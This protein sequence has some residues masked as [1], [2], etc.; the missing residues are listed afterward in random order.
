MTSTLKSHSTSYFDELLYAL[1]NI[2][3]MNEWLCEFPFVFMHWFDCSFIAIDYF[4]HVDSQFI[5]WFNVTTPTHAIVFAQQDVPLHLLNIVYSTI[6]TMTW[7]NLKDTNQ[8]LLNTID[9]KLLIYV[10]SIN[11]FFVHILNTYT[12]LVFIN[13]LIS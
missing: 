6:S 5:I 1:E 7:A 11:N 13:S 4:T 9:I 2:M 8:R 12:T 3:H 10:L